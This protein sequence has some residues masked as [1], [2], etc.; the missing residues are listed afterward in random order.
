MSASL[1]ASQEL[2]AT[3]LREPLCGKA[4]I[5]IM[6]IDEFLPQIWR[7]RAGRFQRRFQRQFQRRFQRRWYAPGGS[8]AKSSTPMGGSFNADGRAPDSNA[9][10]RLLHRS[11][12]VA[13]SHEKADFF[14]I[15]TPMADFNANGIQRQKLALKVLWAS[16]PLGLG[17]GP[18]W[19]HEF[20]A[21]HWSWRPR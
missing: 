2:A 1:R 4:C 18:G 12:K 19:A 7:N 14:K 8:N 5:T 3:S 21:Q 11:P 17:P 6:Q 16:W 10:R 15:S 20:P 13:T 9:K